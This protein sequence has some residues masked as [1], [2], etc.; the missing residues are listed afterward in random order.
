MNIICIKPCYDDGVVS[1]TGKVYFS[2]AKFYS[3]CQIFESLI[4]WTLFNAGDAMLE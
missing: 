1:V 3:W 4:G 2:L